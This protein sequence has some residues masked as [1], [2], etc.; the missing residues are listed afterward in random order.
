MT[1]FG[2]SGPIAFVISA[3]TSFETIDRTHPLMISFQPYANM[4]KQERNDFL[5]EQSSLN[6]RK[7]IATILHQYFTERCLEELDQS[8][9][10]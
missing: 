4:G 10:H 6:P 7:K 9:F 2:L 1:H 8:I 3:Y 5:I